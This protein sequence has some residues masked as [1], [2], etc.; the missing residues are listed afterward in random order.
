M[1]P[2]IVA[3]L[4]CACGACAFAPLA[5]AADAAPAQITLKAPGSLPEGVE[6]DTKNKRFLVG[7]LTEGTVYTVADDGTRTPFIKDPDLK[8][9]VGIEV[10]EERN[11]LLVANSDSAVFRGQGAGQAKL[12]IYD[13]TSGKRIA[14]IDLAAAGPQE[15][16]SHFAN[17][18]TVG[19]DGSVYVTNTMARVVYKVDPKNS[20]SVIVPNTFGTGQVMLNGIVFH[21]S[22]YLLVAES[23]AGDIYKVP[24]TGSGTF[25]K[26][27][28]PEQVTGADG[29][30]MHPDG[31][32]I[33]VR[34]DASRSV[35]ALKSTDE[36]ATAKVDARGQFGAQGTT[37]AVKDGGVYVVQP[38]FA[39]AKAN[40]VIEHV[41]L[42]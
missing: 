27:K 15:A 29:I 42:K 7:S 12:G 16:K 11:R 41:H 34:N 2:K 40:P 4:A 20:V 21:P 25:T 36:W 32:L 22:G 24:L 18:V 17:D 30:L 35:I 33:V 37:A 13:L 8:S 3:L 6:Y 23:T 1:Q 26:V 10:D 5:S 39:D 14:M 31:C 19:K 9:S 38:F 28:L